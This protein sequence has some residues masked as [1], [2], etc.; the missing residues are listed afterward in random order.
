MLAYQA[1]DE[2]AFVEIFRRYRTR[3]YNY[4]LRHLG[5]RAAAQDLLQ[6]VFLKIHRHRKSYRPLG[7]LSAWIFTI[8]TNT[9]RNAAV[10]AARGPAAEARELEGIAPRASLGAK[11]PEEEYAE[12]ELGERVRRAVQSLPP[13]QREVILLAKYEGFKFEEIAEILGVPV[14]TAKVRAHRAIK[15]LAAM[16]APEARRGIDP[17]EAEK[18]PNRPLRAR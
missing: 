15:S 13:S 3:L 5:D 12:R 10:S 18:T 11:S 16:L 14:A 9:L 6:E 4:L 7:S 2:E 1:G 8:A 17:A